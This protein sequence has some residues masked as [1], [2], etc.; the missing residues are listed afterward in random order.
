VFYKGED[1]VSEIK[2]ARGLSYSSFSEY[3]SC[4]KKYFYRKIAKYPIDPDAS[5]STEAFDVGRSLH[6]C[7]ENTKHDLAGFTFQNCVAVCAEFNITDED[8]VAQIMA[9]L[10]KYKKLHEHQ[11]L[12]I[13]ACETIIDTP[14]FH[15]IVDATAYE[16]DVGLW[17]IDV[18]TGATFQQSEISM[19]PS[20]TQL[21][22]YT[23]HF[24][25]IAYAVGLKSIPF[26]GIKLRKI[27]KSKLIRKD[28]EDLQGYIK[29]MSL[30]IRAI[31]LTVPKESLF[32]TEEIY[33][34]HQKAYEIT[35][36]ATLEDEA[37]FA[38]NYSN[39]FSFFRVCPYYSRC[40]GF[41]YTEAPKVEKVEF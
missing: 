31:E 11:K 17:I 22:L 38:R 14:S 35:S 8:T 39:C 2:K 4:Q 40:A 30:G 19:L 27:T 29:R 34:E 7:L 36:K 33:Q 15:G 18:K 1:Q 37:K 3:S 12:K 41:N 6:K 20:H 32:R 23:K 9:M 26:A 5:E 28:G 16:D 25:E 21:N 13:V 10:S 24:D